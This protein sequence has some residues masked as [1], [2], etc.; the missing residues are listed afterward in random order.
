MRVLFHPKFLNHQGSSANAFATAA[1]FN[2]YN[3]FSTLFLI[4]CLKIANCTRRLAVNINLLTLNACVDS[5]CI[6]TGVCVCAY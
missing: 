4:K 2:N 6:H 5:F 3:S 1:D